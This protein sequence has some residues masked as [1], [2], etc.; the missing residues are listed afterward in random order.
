METFG[1]QNLKRFLPL[2]QPRPLRPE[3]AAF[4]MSSGEMVKQSRTLTECSF[5][6][7]HSPAKDQS[8]THSQ[9]TGQA[10][11]TY[12]GAMRMSHKPIACLFN[13]H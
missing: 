12:I 11:V 3:G 13:K 10:C 1:L 5:T 6:I 8:D 7:T 2:L 4:P 9:N